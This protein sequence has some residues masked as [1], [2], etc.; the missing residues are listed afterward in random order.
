[1]ARARATM[2]PFPA[3]ALSTVASILPLLLFAAALGERIMPH[4]WTPLLGLALVSQLLGQGLMIFAL[5]RFSPLVVGI[6]LLTQPVVAATIG[7]LVYDERLGP[8]DMFGAV[9]V[10]VALVLVRKGPKEPDQLAAA[11]ERAR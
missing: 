11:P 8:P 4:D 10:A 6:A 9:L 3:L 5:G 2:A 7:L 1:M